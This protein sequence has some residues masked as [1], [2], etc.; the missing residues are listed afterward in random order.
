MRLQ[1]SALVVM[2]KWKNGDKITKKARSSWS[3]PFGLMKKAHCLSGDI[4]RQES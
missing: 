1:E 3:G 4:R 2:L